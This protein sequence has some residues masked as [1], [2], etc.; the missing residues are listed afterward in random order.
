MS[1]NVDFILGELKKRGYDLHKIA[2]ELGFDPSFVYRVVT[3][4]RNN[5]TVIDYIHEI[6]KS[7]PIVINLDVIKRFRLDNIIDIDYIICEKCQTAFPRSK[8]EENN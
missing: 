6:I 2:K 7:S 3:G 4:E 5:K 1:K 8:N